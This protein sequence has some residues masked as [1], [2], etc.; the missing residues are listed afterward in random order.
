M[1]VWLLFLTQL[2][3]LAFAILGG[4]FLAFSD[5]I[6]RAL[7]GTRGTGGVEAM[8]SINREVFRYI[9]IPLFLAMV[10]ISL[11]LV[12]GAY[13]TVDAP[14]PFLLAALIYIPG[15][16]GVTLVCNVPHA[17]TSDTA[18]VGLNGRKPIKLTVK[19]V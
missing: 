14:A 16:F 6:I 13:M 12:V 17:L 19:S 2:S 3:I 4:V 15:A 10:P 8:Q 1:P 11:I 5:F 18:V 9:F 7:R